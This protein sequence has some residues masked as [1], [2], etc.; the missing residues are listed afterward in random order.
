MTD[1]EPSFW[2]QFWQRNIKKNRRFHNTIINV[3]ELPRFLFKVHLNIITRK[4][5]YSKHTNSCILIQTRIKI[6]KWKSTIFALRRSN[7]PNRFGNFK[8]VIWRQLKIAMKIILK[9][10]DTSNIHSKYWVITWYFWEQKKLTY[11]LHIIL[12]RFITTYLRYLISN[13]FNTSHACIIELKFLLKHQ[14][15]HTKPSKYM[16]TFS[17][18]FRE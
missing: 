11:N 1:F 8:I 16:R 7:F 2:I 9:L 12:Q 5:S 15:T 17:R 3:R 13:C 4:W 18:I 6:E 10:S 14:Y